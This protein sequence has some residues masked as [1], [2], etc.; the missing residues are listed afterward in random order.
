MTVSMGGVGC[1]TLLLANG[2]FRNAGST[3]SFSHILHLAKGWGLRV[4]FITTKAILASHR[5]AKEAG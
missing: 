3:T 4:E 5:N 1:P 2:G